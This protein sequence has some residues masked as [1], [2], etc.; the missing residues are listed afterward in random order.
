MIWHDNA[1]YCRSVSDKGYLLTWTYSPFGSRYRAWA[2]REKGERRGRLLA[3]GSSRFD[4]E[5]ACVEHYA[6]NV[7]RGSVEQ[8][9]ARA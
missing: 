6:R 2:K 5:R 8:A 4:A 7:S 1:R 3:S 9:E